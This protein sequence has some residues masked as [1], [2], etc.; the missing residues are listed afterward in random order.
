MGTIAAILIGGS[1]V[2]V[3][4]GGYLHFQESRGGKIAGE[5]SDS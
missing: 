5:R 4:A 1:I 2:A 3:I